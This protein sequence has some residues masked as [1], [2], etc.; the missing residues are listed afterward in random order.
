MKIAI[1]I[2][3]E[4]IQGVDCRNLENGNPG[5]GGTEYCILLLAQIY[6]KIYS[7][8]EIVLLATT[9]GMLPE[10][11]TVEVISDPLEIGRKFRQIQADMLLISAVYRGEP[12]SQEFFDMIDTNKIKTIF[13]GHNFYL[14]DFCNRIAKCSYAKA[15]VFVGRQQ[16][17]RYLDHSVIKKSTY[18]YNMYPRSVYEARKENTNHAVT[19]I[20]SL[21]PPKGFHVLA[22]AWKSILAEVPDAELNIIGSGKLYGRNSKLGRYGIADEEYEQQFMAGLTD[23]NGNIMP[24]VHFFGVLGEEKAEVIRKTCVGVVNPT[25]KTETFGISALDF[26]SLGVPVVTIGKGGFLDTVI[27]HHT[28]LLYQRYDELVG[29]VVELLKDKEKN[30]RFGEEGIRLAE[31]FA[32]QNIIA[33][34]HDLFELVYRDKKPE[35]RVPDSF[36]WTNLK[37]YRALNRRIKNLCGIEYPMS[38]IGLESFA[39]KVLRKLGK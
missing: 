24:S 20:G 34:W 38:V 26:E 30:I 32:P 5:I 3:N 23:E 27:D 10:V 15:N 36:M 6:K 8:D 31:S 12:L 33:Q 22:Q 13:W 17:D 11:D 29:N 9:Q 2:D 14:S 7:D 25:G 21:V 18:I 37:K 28:G 19:Y 39:R 35:Y 4:N 1:F 16:Y